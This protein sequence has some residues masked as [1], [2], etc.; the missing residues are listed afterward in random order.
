M[1]CQH[2]HKRTWTRFLTSFIASERVAEQTEIA[3]SSPPLTISTHQERFS[4]IPVQDPSLA[5]PL[6]EALL[7][8]REGAEEE[9][10]AGVVQLLDGMFGLGSAGLNIIDRVLAPMACAV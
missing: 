3:W 5:P 8:E 10:G 7:L 6:T 9:A 4:R 2:N 1:A